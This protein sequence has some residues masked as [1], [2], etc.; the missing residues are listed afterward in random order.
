MNKIE[1]A[2][3]IAARLSISQREALT[4]ISAY[5][6]ILADALIDEGMMVSQGFGTFTLWSQSERPGRNPKTGIPVTIPS[7]NSVKFIPGKGLLEY[8][9]SK[10]KRKD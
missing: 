8:L 3:R 9:N 7:R 10:G 2:K 1:F 5:E 4:F 6:N